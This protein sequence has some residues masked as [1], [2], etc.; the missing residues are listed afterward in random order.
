MI[1]KRH[2]NRVFIT[3]HSAADRYRVRVHRFENVGNHLHLL[4]S[5]PSREAFQNFLRTMSGA[6]AMFVTG[7]KKGQGLKKR[8]WDLLAWSR[9]VNWGRDFQ[10]VKTYFFKNALESLGIPR[11]SYQLIPK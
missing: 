8:F 9:V 11:G 2:R 3:V 4:I 5:T 6:I 1:Q 10:V 7:A